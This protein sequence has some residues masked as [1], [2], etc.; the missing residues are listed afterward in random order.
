MGTALAT[1]ASPWTKPLRPRGQSWRQRGRSRLRDTWRRSAP[2][3]AP[4][5]AR[6]TGLGRS[7]ALRTRHA[8]TLAGAYALIL[9]W[10]D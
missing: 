8:E 10:S 6:C 5:W 4:P 2:P 1:P 9:N 3:P 7:S